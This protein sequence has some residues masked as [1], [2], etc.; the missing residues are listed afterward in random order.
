LKEVFNDLDMT[1]EVLEI[2][3]SPETPFFRLSTFG[4]AGS[5]HVSVCIVKHRGFG[6]CRFFP[7]LLCFA[8]YWRWMFVS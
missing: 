7:A 1:S 5:T 4:N 8:L 6:I 3:L 2:L